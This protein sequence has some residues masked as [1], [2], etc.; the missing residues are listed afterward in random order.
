[1][2]FLLLTLR[3]FVLCEPTYNLSHSLTFLDLL[4]PRPQTVAEMRSGVKWRVNWGVM[5]LP[6]HNSD[7]VIQQSEWYYA[8][9][10]LSD[11][12]QL[13]ADSRLAVCGKKKWRNPS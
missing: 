2:A 5:R 13:L 9:L 12:I 8:L 4:S 7:R 11:F 10:K 6:W 1:M 3:V